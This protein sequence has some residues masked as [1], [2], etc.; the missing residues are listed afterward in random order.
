MSQ[1]IPTFETSR[2]TLRP[3]TLAD[4]ASY[5]RYFV[6]Y[7]VVR[8]L[9]RVVPWPYPP[10]GVESYLRDVMLPDQGNTRWSWA[11]TERSGA[12]ELIGLIELFK[13]PG[14][15]NRGFWLG[16]P[17]WGKGYMT[18]AAAR[19]NEFVFNEL[20]WDKIIFDNAKGNHRSARIKEKTG[21]RLIDLTPAEFVDPVLTEMEY[22]ELRREDW[23]KFCR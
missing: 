4:A 3:V 5:E 18:E 7:E 17:F 6:D 9:N 15:S 20:G 16:R 19:L 21:A 11:I 12:G 14:R 2:L 10:G 13:G 23:E 1:P 22:W 8:Y